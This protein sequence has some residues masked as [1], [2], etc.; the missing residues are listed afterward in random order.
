MNVKSSLAFIGVLFLG[1]SAFA[2]GEDKLGPN[3]GFIQ[4]PGAFHTELVP[5]NKS[6]VKVYLLDM[7]WKN[8]TT[9]DSSVNLTYKKRKANCKKQ[10]DHFLCQFKVLNLNKDGELGLV[11]KRENAQGNPQTYELPLKLPE[12][13]PAAADEHSSHH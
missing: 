10:A 7:E 9:T 13:K 4:M 11:A 5:V 3:G 12:A 6:S 8:P 2:H 1:L